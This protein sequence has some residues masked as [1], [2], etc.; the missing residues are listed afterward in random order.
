[1]KK[2]FIMAALLAV[3]MPTA[4][5][6]NRMGPGGGG[7]NLPDKPG[8][9]P[10]PA[11][12]VVEPAPPAPQPPVYTPPPPAPEPAPPVDNPPPPQPPGYQ[13]PAPQ[14]EPHRP[15]GTFRTWGRLPINDGVRVHVTVDHTFEYGTIH[16]YQIAVQDN[17]PNMNDQMVIQGPAGTDDV[18]IDCHNHEE[19]MGYGP[20]DLDFV[21]DIV[22]TYCDW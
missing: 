18:W 17:G 21:H 4:A 3:A 11:P 10:E 6:A 15:Y 7:F 14:P 8:P 2:R 16:G 12:P 5:M 19:W 1:M 22:S 20:N 9:E 13:P